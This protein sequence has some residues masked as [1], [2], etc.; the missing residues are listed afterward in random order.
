MW[1]WSSLTFSEMFSYSLNFFTHDLVTKIAHKFVLVLKRTS[2]QA[3]SPFLSPLVKRHDLIKYSENTQTH[4]HEYI[5]PFIWGKILN[6][7][8]NLTRQWN[9]IGF[10][11]FLFLENR[12]LCTF[13]QLYSPYDIHEAKKIH[14]LVP[15][16]TG[17]RID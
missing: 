2:N 9:C 1:F 16:V 7:M 6:H 13:S 11:K 8:A 14:N 15:I 5:A 17:S 3:G 12:I 10:Q 4:Y